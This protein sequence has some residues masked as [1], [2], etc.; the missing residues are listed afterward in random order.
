MTGIIGRRRHV[1]WLWRILILMVVVVVVAAVGSR[2]VV[3]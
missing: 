1:G 3:I 2:I